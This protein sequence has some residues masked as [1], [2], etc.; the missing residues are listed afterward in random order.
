MFQYPRNNSLAYD[1]AAYFRQDQV[2]NMGREEQ[3]RKALTERARVERKRRVQQEVD[4]RYRDYNE[5]VLEK[6]RVCLTHRAQIKE[7]YE[8]N[9]H[10]A[11][12]KDP[13]NVNLLQAPKERAP[14]GNPN[15]GK[16]SIVFG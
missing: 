1:P 2:D 9:A 4:Q 13:S 16:S 12:W 14:R 11:D 8:R 5:A 7:S 6:E 15:R 10:K 3:K